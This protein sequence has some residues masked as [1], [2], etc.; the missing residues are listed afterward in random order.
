MIL[1]RI[2][3]LIDP[4]SCRVHVNLFYRIVSYRV[5]SWSWFTA[6]CYILTNR[7]IHCNLDTGSWHRRWACYLGVTGD[8]LRFMIRIHLIFT[9][10]VVNI[11]FMK[12]HASWDS[13]GHDFA[14]FITLT[15]RLPNV[16]VSWYTWKIRQSPATQ[17][18]VVDHSNIWY[19]LFLIFSI[20]PSLWVR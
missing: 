1:L 13:N 11:V 8:T 20:S 2:A 3:P 12:T 19:L 15:I 6:S 17:F 9:V 16:T 18:A 5:D 4:S 10:N 7:L 14:A